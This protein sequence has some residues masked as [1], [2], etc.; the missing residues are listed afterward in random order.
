MPITR[1]HFNRN[2]ARK[3]RNDSTLFIPCISIACGGRTTQVYS[4]LI[5]GCAAIHGKTMNCGATAYLETSS[6]RV[7]VFK[8][9]DW[10]RLSPEL[11]DAPPD[12]HPNQ[13]LVHPTINF[14]T[15][16]E[17]SF[18]SQALG[19]N[20]ITRPNTPLHPAILLKTPNRDWKI[21]S[22]FEFDRPLQII[23]SHQTLTSN[24]FGGIAV[25][26]ITNST[27]PEDLNG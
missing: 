11:F 10:R 25:F 12:D 1:V 4:V 19:L 17:F 23:Q 27:M 3:V 8:A 15:A 18:D 20:K 14:A 7:K 6:D 26:G 9:G 22:R 24:L 13:V 5:D 2:F 21:A 16:S